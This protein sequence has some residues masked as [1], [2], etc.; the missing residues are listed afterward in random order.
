MSEHTYAGHTLDEIKRAAESAP[1]A[2]INFKAV[3]NHSTVL[4]MA[5]HI[6]EMRQKM[7][8]VLDVNAVFSRTISEV[9]NVIGYDGKRTLPELVQYVG[10]LE[11]DAARYRQLR[12]GQHWSV[13]DGIGKSLRADELDA[14]IDA[15]EQI[16]NREGV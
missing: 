3:A 12:R 2:A 16:K 13:I 11:R 10:E 7:A 5:A 8:V 6:E 4:A 15:M 9:W 1:I 14:A